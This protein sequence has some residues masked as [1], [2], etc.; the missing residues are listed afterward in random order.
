MVK[1]MPNITLEEECKNISKRT[2]ELL[3]SGNLAKISEEARNAADRS[4]YTGKPDL[5]RLYS[6]MSTLLIYHK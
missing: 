6:P 5:R 2:T 3:K 1:N 4:F